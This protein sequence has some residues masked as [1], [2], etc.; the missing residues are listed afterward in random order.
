MSQGL[1]DSPQGVVRVSVIDE[2]SM[3]LSDIDFCN[4]PGT[5]FSDSIPQAV[6]SSEI[7]HSE[8]AAR[9]PPAFETFGRPTK[10]VKTSASS[11]SKEI[12]KRVPL[13]DSPGFRRRNRRR[14][15]SRRYELFRGAANMREARLPGSS[16]FKTARPPRFQ[17]G[18]I[19]CLA[20]R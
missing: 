6:C 7:P 12:R 10:L 9:R 4:R 1:N 14:Y 16:A 18:K 2:D 15:R 13:T 5:D 20:V 11:P 17:L 3:G 19:R 8:T